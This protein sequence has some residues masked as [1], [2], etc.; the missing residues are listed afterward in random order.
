ME[1]CGE[2]SLDW[3]RFAQCCQHNE[4][5]TMETDIKDEQ[6]AVTNATIDYYE[7]RELEHIR[8]LQRVTAQRDELLAALEDTR[9]LL[10][11]YRRDFPH[12][13]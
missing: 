10:I 3:R 4:S 2:A 12:Q 11:A 13:I 9:D 8:E 7:K 1:K 5:T 6:L